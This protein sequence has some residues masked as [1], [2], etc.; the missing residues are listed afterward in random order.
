VH[1]RGPGAEE[2]PESEEWRRLEKPLAAVRERFPEVLI[3]VDTFRAS[4]AERAAELGADIINDISGGKA[5]PGMYDAIACK[6]LVYVAMHMDGTPATMKTNP[7]YTDVTSAVLM[8]FHEITKALEQKNVTK[9]VFDPGFGFGKS[10][11]N[12]YQLLKNLRVLTTLGYPVLAGVS[13]KSMVSKV[14]GGSS[15]SALNGSTVLHTVALMNGASIL[16]VHDVK[17]AVEAVRLVEF[18]RN[19]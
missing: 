9:I 15:V 17:E 6:D 10:L 7:P 19:A 1:P 12:N 18:Y 16:R 2:I 4:I 3:S 14:T 8:R 11:Q 13:R 5:D